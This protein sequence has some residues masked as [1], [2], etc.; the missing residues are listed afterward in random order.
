MK[1]RQAAAVESAQPFLES[2]PVQLKVTLY[3]D[4]EVVTLTVSRVMLN[5]S[6]HSYQG[7]AAVPYRLAKDLSDPDE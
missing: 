6:L 2:A 7:R 1:Y 5:L 4:Y 3:I